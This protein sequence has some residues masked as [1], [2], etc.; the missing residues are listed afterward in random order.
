MYNDV[1]NKNVTTRETNT[2]NHFSPILYRCMNHGVAGKSGWLIF[3]CLTWREW[4]EALQSTS[5]KVFQLQISR[6]L[7]TG[8]WKTWFKYDSPVD[9]KWLHQA[10]SYIFIRTHAPLLQISIRHKRSQC[11]KI[12]GQNWERIAKFIIHKRSLAICFVCF[13]LWSFK[14]NSMSCS[15]DAKLFC[16]VFTFLP[17]VSAAFCSYSSWKAIFF[18]ST[19]NSLCLTTQYSLTWFIRCSLLNEH[20]TP[21]DF[22][23]VSF[24]FCSYLFIRVSSWSSIVFSI[25]FIGCTIITEFCVVFTVIFSV[26]RN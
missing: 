12:H 16:A 9:M 26:N 8:Y 3:N 21:N 24:V 19:S 15:F 25:Q 4:L 18:I 5:P 7:L 13:C 20:C 11:E 14:P 22:H 1:N 23:L 10:R 17:I 2:N 6:P